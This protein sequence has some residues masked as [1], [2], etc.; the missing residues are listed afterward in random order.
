MHELTKFHQPSGS[1]HTPA[2]T[3]V[4]SQRPSSLVEGDDSRVQVG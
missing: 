4:V 1:I 3:I 2:D